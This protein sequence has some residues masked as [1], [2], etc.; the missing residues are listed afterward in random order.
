[1]ILPPDGLLTSFQDH[2]ATHHMSPLK[3]IDTLQARTHQVLRH[4]RVTATRQYSQPL[5]PIAIVSPSTCSNLI[6]KS[7]RT[8]LQVVR[9]LSLLA[10]LVY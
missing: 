8:S 6:R 4:Y 7:Q 10:T 5:S 2:R 1:M 3:V 9:W